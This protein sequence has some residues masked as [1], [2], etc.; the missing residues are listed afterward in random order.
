M[1]N[2]MIID[3]KDNVVVAIEPIKAGDEVSYMLEGQTCSL[4]AATDVTIY[5]K[6]ARAVKQEVHHLSYYILQI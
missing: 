2:A 1:I 6:L 3:P 4:Y 5:H